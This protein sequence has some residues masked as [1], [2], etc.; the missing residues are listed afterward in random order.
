MTTRARAAGASH[1]CRRSRMLAVRSAWRHVQAHV[2]PCARGRSQP[3]DEAQV[4]NLHSAAMA[5][6]GRMKSRLAP[7]KA[8]GSPGQTPGYSTDEVAVGGAPPMVASF[9]DM[10]PLSPALPLAAQPLKII[11]ATVSAPASLAGNLLLKPAG[12]SWR[13][14]QKL[15]RTTCAEIAEA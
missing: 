10:E 1:Y 15:N 13:S 8:T 14:H 12:L 9:P 7:S 4:N 11:T 6:G 5:V 2:V 3:R